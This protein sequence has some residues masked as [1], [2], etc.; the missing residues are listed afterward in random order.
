MKG[1][2]VAVLA[3]VSTGFACS[4]A[5]YVP[6]GPLAK[7]LTGFDRI[8]VRALQNK[9]PPK[10]AEQATVS[11]DKFIEFFRKDLTARL[12]RRKAFDLASGPQLIVDGSVLRY[13]CES[14]PPTHAKDNMTNKATVEVEIVL[15]DQAGARLGG[16]KCFIEYLGSTQDG[17]LNGAETRISR[18]IAAYLRKPAKSDPDD[19]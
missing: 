19:P 1:R 8:D 6:D 3:I 4:R 7:P 15:T 10:T 17:A 14:R 13:Q 5:D 18:A 11:P 9:V 16:G 2:F 12:H